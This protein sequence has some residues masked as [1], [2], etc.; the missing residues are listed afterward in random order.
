MVKDKKKYFAKGVES[1]SNEEGRMGEGV[2]AEGGG[3]GWK[4]GGG[5]VDSSPA[6]IDQNNL[7]IES[8]TSSIIPARFKL[9]TIR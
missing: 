9:K 8:A 6:I 7:K 5:R 1:N 3:G 2:G 4:G